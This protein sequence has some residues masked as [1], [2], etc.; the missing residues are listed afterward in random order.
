MIVS[1]GPAVVSNA[2]QQ[3]FNQITCGDIDPNDEQA[4]G[5]SLQDLFV[6][7][8]SNGEKQFEGKLE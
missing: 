2:N 5:F 4:S 6:T 1:T 7:F 8:E 3:V